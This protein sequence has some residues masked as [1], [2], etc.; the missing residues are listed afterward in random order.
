MGNP[1]N[2]KHHTITKIHSGLV[3]QKRG[4]VKKK[5]KQI[6]QN[7]LGLLTKRKTI[8]RE[9]IGNPLNFKHHIIT[10]VLVWFYPKGE[11]A[12]KIGQTNLAKQTWPN[13]LGQTNLDFSQKKQEY[14]LKNSPRFSFTRKGFSFLT[15][16]LGQRN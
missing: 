5:Y 7:K 1:S 3:L 9:Q 2:I 6:W 15:N 12:N 11:N 4:K 8:D 14:H 10:R 16:K 13:K